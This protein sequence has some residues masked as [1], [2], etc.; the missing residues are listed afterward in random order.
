MMLLFALRNKISESLSF[1]KCEPRCSSVVPVSSEVVC[2][3]EE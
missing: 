3:T 1:K 2:L